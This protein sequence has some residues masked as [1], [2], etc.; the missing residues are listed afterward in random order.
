MTTNTNIYLFSLQ[1]NMFFFV[2]IIYLPLFIISMQHTNSPLDHMFLFFPTNIKCFY[3]P[4]YIVYFY[5]LSFIVSTCSC[6]ISYICIFYNNNLNLILK[7]VSLTYAI[8]LLLLMTCFDIVHI[9]CFVPVVK[10]KSLWHL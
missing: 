4:L 7:Q 9:H 1:T 5:V 6:C 3:L 2:Y 10:Q 8:Y